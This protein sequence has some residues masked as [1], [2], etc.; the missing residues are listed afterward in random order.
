M[1]SVTKEHFFLSFTENNPHPTKTVAT[2]TQ[3]KPLFRWTCLLLP[4]IP[5]FFS[6]PLY[7]WQLIRKPPPKYTYFPHFLWRSWLS[8]K[9]TA[10]C[11]P[12]HFDST[13]VGKQTLCPTIDRVST[14]VYPLW[15][16][17]PTGSRPGYVFFFF[18]SLKP[19]WWHKGNSDSENDRQSMNEA[20]LD[21]PN[22][23]SLWI[24]WFQRQIRHY[25]SYQGVKYTWTNTHIRMRAHALPFKCKHMLP[26]LL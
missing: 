2:A 24:W 14:A 15:A 25:K 20:K 17:K 7:I 3:K 11:R 13:A 16:D 8:S 26:D 12:S 23:K 4:F 19:L 6:S 18:F 21:L 22:T 5:L 9:Q 1:D 10:D